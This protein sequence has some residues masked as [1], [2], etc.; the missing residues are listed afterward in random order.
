LQ[1]PWRQGRRAA[2]EHPQEGFI[3]GLMDKI[4]AAGGSRETEILV[5]I[6]IESLISV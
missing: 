4:A 3:E 5:G 2:S 6:L 1:R